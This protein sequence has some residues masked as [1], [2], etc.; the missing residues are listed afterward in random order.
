VSDAPL[1]VTVGEDGRTYV[2]G[3]AIADHRRKVRV[4]LV[5]AL[6]DD[7]RT[8]LPAP[9]CRAPERIASQ[10]QATLNGPWSLHSIDVAKQP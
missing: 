7:W 4:V 8:R 10:I 3:V 6:Y 1:P 2:G 9:E 5:L